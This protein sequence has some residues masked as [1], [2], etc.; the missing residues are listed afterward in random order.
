M[1]LGAQVGVALPSLLVF[2]RLSLI[3]TVANLVAVPVAGLVMLYGLPAALLAGVAPP[4]APVVM[5]P[6][7]IGVRR[8]DAVATVGAAAEPGPPWSWIGWLAVAALVVALVR[9]GSATPPVG[10]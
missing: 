1:T 4:L 2:G 5:A 6:V 9:F 3:G 8:I 10:P 7:G